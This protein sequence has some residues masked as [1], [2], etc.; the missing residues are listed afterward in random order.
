MPKI[1][2]T[3]SPEQPK[4]NQTYFRQLLTVFHLYFTVFSAFQFEF[5]WPPSITSRKWFSQPQI[6]FQ[7][8]KWQLMLK[9]YLEHA[10]LM[11]RCSICFFRRISSCKW[12]FLR[13]KESIQRQ[14]IFYVVLTCSG[15]C[16]ET[17]GGESEKDLFKIFLFV[18][19]RLL[20]IFSSRKFLHLSFECILL[21]I[22]PFRPYFIAFDRDQ[23][24][25]GMRDF[26]RKIGRRD[27][28]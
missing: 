18:F 16:Q 25:V 11:L 19:L 4:C 20:S 5:F 14:P 12:S 10:E 17:S 24:A 28:K 6:E 8:R 22:F 21:I 9:L 3:E 7:L 1:G 26:Q 27:V 2:N 13:Q 15:C 23:S